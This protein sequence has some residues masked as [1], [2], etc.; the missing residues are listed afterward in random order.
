MKYQ[1]MLV[2]KYPYYV[3]IGPA[4]ACN[5]HRHPEIELNLCIKGSYELQIDKKKYVMSPNHLAIM[6]STISHSMGSSNHPDVLTLTIE[7]SPVLLMDY[8]EPF[9]KAI[10]PSPIFC[11]TDCEPK[12]T[13]L[14]Y[15]TAKLCQN[16]TGLAELMIQGNLYKICYFIYEEFIR[17][18]EHKPKPRAFRD[19]QKVEEAMEM[20]HSQYNQPLTLEYVASQVQYSESH[21]C[22]IFKNITGITFHD[23]LNRCRIRNA[24]C[25]L[26]E[27]TV[28]ISEIA[29]QVGF[30]STK[31]FC[32]VFKQYTGYT[33]KR[34]R[35]DD[36]LSLNDFH[37]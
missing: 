37:L 23:A 30:T 4:K 27:T 9:S 15:E 33:P 6:G 32:Y 35:N 2:G 28:P 25:R 16:R 10:F 24:C 11:L 13:E 19:V 17:P 22:R 29:L 20:I 14:L 21:F 3:S 8:F 34:F 5:E 12:L 26:K 7:I 1:D 31:T 36:T 18:T